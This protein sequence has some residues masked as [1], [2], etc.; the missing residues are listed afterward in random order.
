MQADL[1]VDRVAPY[2]HRG[3]NAE[4]PSNMDVDR[5]AT[6]APF[7]QTPAAEQSRD[8]AGAASSATA[9]DHGVGRLEDVL[10]SIDEHLDRAR[11]G[12][13]ALSVAALRLHQVSDTLEPYNL[14]QTVEGAVRDFGNLTRFD[15]VLSD[16]AVWLI[17]P[18]M[19]PKRARAVTEHLNVALGGRRDDEAKIVVVGFPNDATTAERLVQRCV[20]L[21]AE[22]QARPSRR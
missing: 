19:L 21:L 18:D 11:V 4:E 6:S 5:E 15:V 1:M 17:L 3:Q 9:T 8:A 20:H 13:Y 16:D 10:A 12:H 2:T 7:A 14:R 22:W